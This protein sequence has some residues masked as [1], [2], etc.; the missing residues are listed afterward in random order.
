MPR[1]AT[2]LS[3][4]MK[5]R[6][7]TVELLTPSPRFYRLPVPAYIKKWFG[8]IDQ[9]ILFPRAVKKRLKK[10]HQECL[11]IFTDQALGPWIP[12]VKDRPHVIHCHDFLAQR[13]AL[14]E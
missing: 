10:M 13:S 1:F 4:G 2:M 14:G 8:Y 7:H 5:Q 9:Y 3:D 11:F 6:G 12:L